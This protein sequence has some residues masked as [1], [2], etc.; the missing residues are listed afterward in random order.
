[1]E[2]RGKREK[3]ERKKAR[4]QERKGAQRNET[5]TSSSATKDM[6]WRIVGDSCLLLAGI[7]ALLAGSVCSCAG[8]LAFTANNSTITIVIVVVVVV[9]AAVCDGPVAWWPGGARTRI[10]CGGG[11]GHAADAAHNL[12][13]SDRVAV[14]AVVAVVGEGGV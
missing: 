3:R 1:M 2:S 14:V 6:G 4:K 11:R 5:G 13:G 8:I 9:V 10:A 12:R 7:T